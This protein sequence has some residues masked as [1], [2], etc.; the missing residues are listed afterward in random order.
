MCNIFIE[1]NHFQSVDNVFVALQLLC[2][3]HIIVVEVC[4]N[5]SSTEHYDWF[6]CFSSVV[7]DLFPY[8]ERINGVISEMIPG[9]QQYSSPYRKFNWEKPLGHPA[10]PVQIKAN[11][12]IKFKPL[13]SERALESVDWVFNK[14]F[15]RSSA[16]S[17]SNV[18]R[19]WQWKC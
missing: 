1:H 7:S 18:D 11:A 13:A 14:I 3:R 19:F 15:W 2:R 12:A 5:M 8:S 17:I 4:L 10:T 6:G 16:F 9:D